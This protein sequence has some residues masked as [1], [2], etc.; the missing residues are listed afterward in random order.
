MSNQ[1]TAEWYEAR[2]G[3]F[4]SSEIYKLMGTPKSKTETLTDTAKT[5][6]YEKLAELLTGKPSEIF[7]PALD[8]GIEH[9]PMAREWYERTTGNQVYDADFVPFGRYSGGSPDG[10]VGEH[11][12]VEFKCPFNSVNHVKYLTATSPD[13]LPTEYYWQI[14]ANLMFTGRGWAHFVSFDP[15][16]KRKENGLFIMQIEA[17]KPE[18]ELIREKI[19]LA[20]VMFNS[21]YEKLTGYAITA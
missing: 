13:D 20:A 3:R 5:F 19:E 9:E 14:Q 1:R 8:W 6:V 21:I 7:G 18:H 17:I 10:Y 2:L 16:M 15:R 4:T 12:I 11:G